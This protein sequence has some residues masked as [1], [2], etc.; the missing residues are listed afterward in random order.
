MFSLYTQVTLA[1]I[2]SQAELL[3]H[4]RGRRW[5]QR[6]R[7]PQCTLCVW[8]GVFHTPSSSLFLRCAR[9]VLRDRTGCQSIGVRE[10]PIGCTPRADLRAT[11]LRTSC[12]PF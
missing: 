11:G 9:R 7:H 5:F 4:R 1:V 3:R 2:F 8:N 6:T 12:H 10:Q